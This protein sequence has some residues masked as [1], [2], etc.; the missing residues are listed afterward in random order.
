MGEKLIEALA[1]S[2]GKHHIEI[3]LNSSVSSTNCLSMTHEG[4][5]IFEVSVTCHLSV[6]HRDKV[7]IKGYKALFG[8][9][10][11]CVFLMV[12]NECNISGR[13]ARGMGH[14]R[15]NTTGQG[16]TSPRSGETIQ[17]FS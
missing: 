14:S 9:M 10:H 11:I 13:C 1:P 3:E 2:A 7:F 12:D 16:F 4:N 6:K 17:R 5:G 8:Q 15:R